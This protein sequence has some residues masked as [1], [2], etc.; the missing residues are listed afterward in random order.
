MKTRHIFC[1]MA[2][3]AGLMLLPGCSL[4][5]KVTSSPAKKTATAVELPSDRQSIASKKVSTDYT[6]E[7]IKKGV[8]KGDWAIEMVFGKNVVGE[9]PPFLKFVPS[10]NR[11][12]GNNGCNVINA[13]YQYNAKDST[14]SFDHLAST[15]RLC[16]K[17]GLT[18]YEINTAL[19]STRFYSVTVRDNDYFLRFYDETGREVMLLMHQ[20]FEFLNGTWRV[21]KIND[22]AVNVE[23]LKMVI[24]VDEGKVHGDTGCNIF[25]GRLDVD[26]EHPN[27]ISFSAIALTRMM[28]PDIQYET[29]FMVALEEVAA[30][31]P[32]SGNEVVLYSDQ[33]KPVLTLVR[34]ADK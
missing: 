8:V 1:G 11:V 31:K 26:M 13:D 27:S 15:M 22:Q 7:E 29:T 10:E 30:A 18:D 2:A 34:T 9:E 5:E 23:G 24:D 14:I 19:G 4:F 25:N 3:I 33:N 32:V 28:C 20:N 16:A 17:E 6:P 12:Y 21:A